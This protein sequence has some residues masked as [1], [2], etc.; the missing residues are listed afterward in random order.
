MSAGRLLLIRHGQTGGNKQRYVGW[1]DV[2]L[3]ETGVAQARAVAELL[4]G[5]PIDAI[6][7]SPLSRAVDTA[8]PLAAARGL[9]IRVREE[10]KEIDYGRFRG[11]LKT[12]Q[13][14]KLRR[15]HL[16]APMPGGESLH[17]VFLR[18][19]RF[20]REAA[21]E[22]AAGRSLAVVGH[23]WSNRM[24]VGALGGVPFEE[25]FARSKYKPANGSIYELACRGAGDA[26]I[27]SERWIG[28]QCEGGEP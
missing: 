6:Y 3:D 27:A 19:S 28:P 1:E 14:L 5:E 20:A 2:P 24:L 18:V 12:D 23:F 13:P 7:S 10:I 21:A 9:G 25:L 11:L 16:T 8:R 22:L 26:T 4:A 15:E 17:D